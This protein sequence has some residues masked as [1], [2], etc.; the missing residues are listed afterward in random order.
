V[1]APEAVA[2]LSQDAGGA[3]LAYRRYQ[4]RHAAAEH[5]RQIGTAKS[6]PSR[7]AA[8]STSRTGPVTKPSRSAVAADSE[9][10]AEPPASSAAPALVMVRREPWVSAATSYVR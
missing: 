1:A 7:A 5:D 8:R 3:C 4:I 6:M 9:P 10:G 2:G